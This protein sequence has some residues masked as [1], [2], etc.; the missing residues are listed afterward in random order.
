M[1]LPDPM[2]S[3]AGYLSSLS[4]LYTSISELI[5]SNGSTD[6]ASDLQYKLIARYTAYLES[7][8]LALASAPEKED[9]MLKSHDHNE[10]RYKRVLAELEVYVIEGPKPEESLHAAS[11]FSRR[12]GT[13]KPASTSKRSHDRGSQASRANSDRMSEA[14]VQAKLQLLKAQQLKAIHEKEMRQ[15]QLE[16]ETELRRREEESRRSEEDAKRRQEDAQAALR[17]KQL[18]QDIE[19]QQQMNK[20]AELNAEVEIRQREAVRLDIGSDYESDDERE[21][22][23]QRDLPAPKTTT[24]WQPEQRQQQDLTGLL[25][26]ASAQ[27]KQCRLKRWH[28]TVTNTRLTG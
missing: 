15:Q 25:K 22:V 18:Q 19:F 12:S 23:T 13:R 20:V 16:A 14:R 2:R 5:Q 28:V 26:L 3:R 27:E 24:T 10:E 8:E 17:R 21:D 1:A 9:S 4:K 7:H 11:L 6:E